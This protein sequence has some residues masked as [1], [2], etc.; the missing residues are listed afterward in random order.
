V[1][2][3]SDALTA[4]QRP[5]LA[6]LEKA[7]VAGE[8][9]PD[10]DDDEAMSARGYLVMRLEDCGMRD[11]VDIAFLL[12][13]LDVLR[14]WGVSAPTMSERV[15]EAKDEKATKGQ[16]DYITDLTKRLVVDPPEFME[17]LTKEQA[18]AIIE[19]LKAGTYKAEEYRVPF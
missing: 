19:R 1:T 16:L 17:A 13:A 15:T 4:A 9:D 7:Y 2:P 3:L 10:P 5:A 12:A 8:L 11:P 14:E 6:A 18:S